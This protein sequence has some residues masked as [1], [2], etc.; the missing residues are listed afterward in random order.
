MDNSLSRTRKI[1]LI[2][3]A[4][5]SASIQVRGATSADKDLPEQILQTMLHVPGTTQDHRPVHAKGLFCEGTFTPSPDAAGLSMAGHFQGPVPVTVRFSDGATDPMVRDNVPE[6]G[7]RGLAIR[8]RLS[9]GGLMDI[10]AMSHN[11]FVVSNGQEFLAL[12]KAVVATDPSKPHPWPV[13]EFLGAHPAAMKFVKENGIV[14]DSFAT[15][16]FFSNDSFVFVNKDGKKQAGRYQF[17]PVAGVHHLEAEEAK[18]R[19][20]NYLHDELKTRLGSAP[21]EFRMVVQL[22][23]PGDSTADPSVV[24]PDDRKKIEVG[25]IRLTSARPDENVP[26]KDVAFDPA[27][28]VLGIELSDDGLP[29]LRS[30]VYALSVKNRRGAH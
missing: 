14:P 26:D 15:E 10:V 17:I 29:A 30:K 6:A 27:K 23:N 2:T 25:T 3:T 1:V 18:S 12:Q 22:P 7:P 8:F 21:V 11:G 24:W 16:A 13:E 28:L 5:L 19:S 4:F 20:E 9:G